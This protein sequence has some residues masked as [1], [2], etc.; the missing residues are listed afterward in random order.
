MHRPYVKFVNFWKLEQC[1]K[2]NY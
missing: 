2:L 1:S